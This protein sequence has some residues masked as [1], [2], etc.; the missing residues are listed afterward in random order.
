MTL[1]VAIAAMICALAAAGGAALFVRWAARTRV[2][3]RGQR[4]EIARTATR[5][6][7][8]AADIRERLAGSVDAMDRLRM[9]G[10]LLDDRT[11]ALVA[12]LGERRRGMERITQ[13]RL[14]TVIGLASLAS[15]A[16][17]VAFLWR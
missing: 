8:N 16:A 2:A 11:M 14:A 5:T 15:K 4:H 6:S 13:G 10:E 3:L 17:R 12:W 1:P 9:Q 7:R